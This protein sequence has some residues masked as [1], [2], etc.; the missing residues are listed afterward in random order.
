MGVFLVIGIKNIS[1]S[2][3][4]GKWRKLAKKFAKLDQLLENAQKDDVILHLVQLKIQACETAIE[5][6]N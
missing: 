1:I 2:Y 3:Q 4:D 5:V 6:T